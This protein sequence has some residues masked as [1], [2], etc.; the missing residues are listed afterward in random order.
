MTPLDIKIELLRAGISQADIA[1]ECGVS[2]SQ[3]NR[4][5]GNLCVSDHVRRTIA[6]AI[7]K[8]VENVWPEY[9]QRSTDSACVR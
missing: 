5:I 9:Y 8:G 3:V 6:T 2:R 4:V 1:R 7:G